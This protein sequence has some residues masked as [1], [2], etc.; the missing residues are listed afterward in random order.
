MNK[1]KDNIKPGIKLEDQKKDNINF[2]ELKMYKKD[3]N[4]K[5][6]ILK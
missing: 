2:D 3:K 4:K 5:I 1:K 6:L